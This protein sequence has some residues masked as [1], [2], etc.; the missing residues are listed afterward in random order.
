MYRMMVI[1]M[2]L[3]VT[4]CGASYLVGHGPDDPGLERAFEEIKDR[5][6][7]LTLVDGTEFEGNLTALAHD[8]LQ[9]HWNDFGLP[10]LINAR[11]LRSVTTRPNR[12]LPTFAGILVGGSLGALIGAA[13]A[14]NG[15][16]AAYEIISEHD[17][18]V[19]V[20]AIL[21]ASIGGG[22]GNAL[23][24]PTEVTFTELESRDL[25]IVARE[26]IV[27][28]VPEICFK[29]SYVEFVSSD[30]MVNLPEN[31]IQ[32]ERMQGR[33]LVHASP[34][35]IQSRP[36]DTHLR[37][38]P[39]YLKNARHAAVTVPEISE[40][41]GF[42]SFSLGGKSIRLSSRE[43]KLERTASGVVITAAPETFRAAG[44]NLE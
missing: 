16:H 26:T 31:Q 36:S 33:I 7:T 30:G 32:I 44:L 41:G 18:A 29:G 20:G 42:V 27:F 11:Q 10:I 14:P 9:F 39:L 6:V 25:P 15:H 34:V 1:A 40:E 17:I 35:N 43:V 4:G 8:T 28:V 23:S 24:A 38:I 37:G 19:T 3:V 5:T 22:T 2:A 13:A 12:I 21:G